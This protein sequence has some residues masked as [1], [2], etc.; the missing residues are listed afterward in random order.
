MGNSMIKS[1][2]SDIG[3]FFIQNEDEA[4]IIGWWSQDDAS[5]VID[6]INATAYPTITRVEEKIEE[7]KEELDPA[8]WYSIRR[9][10]S[11]PIISKFQEYREDPPIKYI[12]KN[13]NTDYKLAEGM[14]LLD[15]TGEKPKAF[16]IS[17]IN[18][19]GSVFSV[20]S[21]FP[22]SI[23]Y[24]SASNIIDGIK[25]GDFQVLWKPEQIE[26][27]KEEKKEEEVVVGMILLSTSD[28]VKKPYMVNK[29]V[30]DSAHLRQPG[31]KDELIVTVVQ[32]SND[33]CDSVWEVVYDPRDDQ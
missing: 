7:L 12:E 3:W 11:E 33:I 8:E 10:D 18:E 17:Q 9:V 5:W 20:S 30:D 23:S 4:G 32:L 19:K 6:P 22:V 14:V 26:F 15:K 1:E 21:D 31:E 24:D 2:T 16:L 13:S 25:H 29:I 28:A 27:V